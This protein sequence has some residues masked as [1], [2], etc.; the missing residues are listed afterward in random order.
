MENVYVVKFRHYEC[1]NLIIEY[2]IKSANKNIAVMDALRAISK[3]TNIP[4]S[5]FIYEDCV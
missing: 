3:E 1:A 4:M 2:T 5:N